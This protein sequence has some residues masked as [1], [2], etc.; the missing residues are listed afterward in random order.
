MRNVN[1]G[2]YTCKTCRSEIDKDA[3]GAQHGGAIARQ[4][5]GLARN[6]KLP[7]DIRLRIAQDITDMSDAAWAAVWV[8]VRRTFGE[9]LR[10]ASSAARGSDA[11]GTNRK[12]V[13]S[14]TTLGD[15]SVAHMLGREHIAGVPLWDSNTPWPPTG[16]TVLRSVERAAQIRRLAAGGVGLCADTLAATEAVWAAHT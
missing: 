8:D 7:R 2:Q 9:T 16:V 5:R 4:L 12:L 14:L 6:T 10:T 15:A 1:R 3:R 13:Y 11:L